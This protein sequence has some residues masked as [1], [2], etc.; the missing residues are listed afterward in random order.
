MKTLTTT[1]VRR[2][3]LYLF[4]LS[5]QHS[6]ENSPLF[7]TLT[8]FYP[9]QRY[10]TGEARCVTKWSNEDE[11]TNAAMLMPNSL[12]FDITTTTTSNS[13]ASGGETGKDTRQ[14]VFVDLHRTPLPERQVASTIQHVP[15]TQ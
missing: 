6:N 7:P 4:L 13:D 5:I 12:L 1:C 11:E 15:M 2:T 3:R 8:H 9:H 14:Y 10:A